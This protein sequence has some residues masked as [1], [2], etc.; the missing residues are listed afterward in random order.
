MG[1]DDEKNACFAIISKICKISK[2]ELNAEEKMFVYSR[3]AKALG[4]R[5]TLKALELIWDEAP[6]RIPSTSE[7]KKVLSKSF[8]FKNNIQDIVHQIQLLI[9]SKGIYGYQEARA[10]AQNQNILWAFD[11][12]FERP[13]YYRTYCG[14]VRNDQWTLY[15]AHWSKILISAHEEWFDRELVRYVAEQNGIEYKAPEQ[16]TQ[17]P[18]ATPDPQTQDNLLGI[19]F[20]AKTTG[21]PIPV[22]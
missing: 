18:K 8:Q 19:E 21:K 2:V 5:L 13:G 22:S 9:Q 3:Y 6:N 14:S 1:T 16:L 20:M 17:A 12:I 11:K 4:S 15:A 10:E 7:L